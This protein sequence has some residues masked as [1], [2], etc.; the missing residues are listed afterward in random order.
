MAATNA[1]STVE[2]ATGPLKVF[3]RGPNAQMT[4]APTSGNSHTAKSSGY[5]PSS[6]I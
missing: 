2:Q 4:I 1:S 3:K 6:P 5:V